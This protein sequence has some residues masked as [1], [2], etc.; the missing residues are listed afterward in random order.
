MVR[1]RVFD[2]TD[3]RMSFWQSAE[4]L[5]AV[6]TRNIG[7]LFDLYL[8]CHPSCSQ[9]H[10]ALLT[11]H[12]RSDVSNLMRGG[13]S[14]VV[15]DID[16]LTRIARGLSM[17]DPARVAMGLAPS[18]GGSESVALSK[19]SD[20]LGLRTGWYGDGRTP[21]KQVALCGSRSSE[22]DDCALDSAVRALGAMLAR[23]P[24]NVCHGP[25]GIGVE[26]VTFIADNY[27]P[28]G[29]AVAVGII[30]HQNVV[31]NADFVLVLGG[32][33][34]TMVECDLAAAMAKTI[35]PFPASGG[36]ALSWYEHMKSNGCVGKGISEAEYSTLAEA[37]AGQY[38]LIVEKVLAQ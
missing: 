25:L 27:R 18:S 3:V 22:A 34:G 20:T 38:G 29:L 26:I 7:Q 14:P 21:V 13:R 28:P 2:P 10:L 33:H 35:I 16:V 12:D 5:E 8:K 17:P 31:R 9:S 19:E 11:E 6:V 15:R 30:G 36:S 37:D 23:V 1:K 32:G 4:V 24:L